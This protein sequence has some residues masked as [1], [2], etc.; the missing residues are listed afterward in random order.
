MWQL[1]TSG[2]WRVAVGKEHEFVAAWRDMA[3]WTVQNV[4]GN[5]PAT[6]LQDRDDPRHFVSFGPWESI[7]AIQAWRASEGFQQRVA[8]IRELLE[9]FEPMTGEVVADAG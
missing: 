5:G 3:E 6:L 2:T 8:R 4:P 7:Q 1:F 9:S